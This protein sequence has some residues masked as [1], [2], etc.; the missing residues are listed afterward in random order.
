MLS[1]ERPQIEE[2][3]LFDGFEITSR[4]VIQPEI[5]ASKPLYKRSFSKNPLSFLDLFL[6]VKIS[7]YGKKYFDSSISSFGN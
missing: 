2:L 5:A 7:V 1:I 3:A 6:A 4:K